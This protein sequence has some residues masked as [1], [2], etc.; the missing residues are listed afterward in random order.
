MSSCCYHDD[1]GWLDSKQKD[2][3]GT[4]SRIIKIGQMER[5]KFCIIG[6]GNIGKTSF[7][8]KYCNDTFDENQTTTILDSKPHIKEFNGKKICLR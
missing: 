8:Q 7:F 1:K 5:K 2:Q 3:S 4:N 6:D